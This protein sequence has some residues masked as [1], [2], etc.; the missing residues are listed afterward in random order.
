MSATYIMNRE[1]APNSV[2]Q[3]ACKRTV[4]GW[5]F[6]ESGLYALKPSRNQHQSPTLFMHSMTNTTLPSNNISKNPQEPTITL[7]KKIFPNSPL[8][9]PQSRIKYSLHVDSAPFIL[10][11][12]WRAQ[13]RTWYGHFQLE[14]TWI[15]PLQA[16]RSLWAAYLF[17]WELLLNF[18]VRFK[19]AARMQQSNPRAQPKL[20]LCQKQ[21][22]HQYS[23]RANK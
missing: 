21:A 23:P 1:N 6:E 13:V 4:C 2:I 5:R 20:N 18:A 9:S 17:T 8:H 10:P 12:L 11:P 22:K 7:S 16:A 3:K 14:S 19:A 15:L